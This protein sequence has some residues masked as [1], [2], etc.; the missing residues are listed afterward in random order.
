[1]KTMYSTVFLNEKNTCTAK[2]FL[3]YLYSESAPYIQMV[4]LADLQTRLANV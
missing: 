4:E 3:D 2:D 1:M